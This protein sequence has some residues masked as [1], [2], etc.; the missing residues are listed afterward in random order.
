MGFDGLII[1]DSLGMGGIV[2]AFT[3]KDASVM[4]LKAGA[5]ILLFGA[6]KQLGPEDQII[7]FRHILSQVY[8]GGIPMERIDE[9]VRRILKTKIQYG[10]LDGA[11]VNIDE[12]PGKVGTEKHLAIAKLV[13]RDSITLLKDENGYV[14]VNSEKPILII[15][16]QTD[17]I[18]EDYL[19]MY[20]L[21]VRSIS[22]SPD[23]DDIEIDHAVSASKDYHQVIAG[24][25][26]VQ[27]HAGQ[28]R[29]IKKLYNSNTDMIVV[30]M[31]TP[32]DLL[33]FR[34]IPC[35]MTTYGTNPVSLYALAR[36]L[37]GLEKPRGRLPVELPGIFPIGHGL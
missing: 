21:Q 26:E 22:I 28:K 16:P 4:A 14:P 2:K 8:S 19:N 15:W 34:E 13:A 33:F 31:G 10:L 11:K 17:H 1:T 24:T 18:L 32:Y 25:Y 3:I 12:I 30:S 6:D 36:V 37:I 9:S 5:D 23:P 29:L 35:Y 20:H 7:V 27:K